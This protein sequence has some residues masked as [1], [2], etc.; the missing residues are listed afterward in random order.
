MPE[1]KTP[2]TLSELVDVLRASD[3]EARV[4][5]DGATCVDG[6]AIDSR[7][8]RPGNLFVCKGAGFRPAF[9]EGAVQAGAAAY[10]CEGVGEGLSVPSE[11]VAAAAVTPALV[12]RDVRRAM[13]LVAP[14]IYRHPEDQLHVV[15][16]T[17][18]KGKSTVAYMLRSILIAAGQEPSILGSIATDDGKVHYES[19]NTTPE[20]PDLWR[21]LRNTVDAGRRTMVME[22]SSQGLKYDRVLGLPLEIGC[23][24]NIG[25]DHISGVEH[26]NFEDYFSSKLRIFNQCE[27]AV[28][29]LATEH[30][31]RVLEAAQAAPCVATFA[32]EHAGESTLAN[33]PIEPL[34]SAVGVTS[35]PGGGLAFTVRER[36]SEGEIACKERIELGMP[37]LFNVDN[38]LA[39]IAMARLL[40]VGY[41]AI[42][43]GLAHVRVPGRMEL[44]SSAD[45]HVLAIVDY[46]HN[47]LSFETL[48]KSV[49]AE[50]PDR[51]VVALF[52][53]P[54]GKAHERRE[55]L[56]RVAGS[57]A[58][59]LVYTEDEPAHD[60]VEDICA[61]LV[62][63]TPEGVSCEV[64]LDRE[65]AVTQVLTRALEASEPS[66]VMLLAKGDEETM[67]RG[68]EYPTI[69]S[70][71]T[72]A[73]EV[74]EA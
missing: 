30:V 21:H 11:L 48:F 43:A 60:R 1:E 42:R 56:P 32:V 10:L 46:A 62:E 41:D 20:A 26:P 67:H 6:M 64:I 36:G 35:L 61:A 40:G 39:A 27:V 51:R 31:D 23:F 22:V 38:A 63:H 37:G 3:V 7:E 18:T 8:V 24:L 65:E 33:A 49:K 72:L 34:F 47:E 69:K 66:V 59:H 73:R 15:G 71:L 45:G 17:G 25:R 2:L 57:Y 55:A 19:H 5:G 4:L 44:V 54:G 74:L 68:D 58:D 14:V 16:I 52:G 50:Y 13:A 29:N 70:D 28:V 9:L 53:A 12:V